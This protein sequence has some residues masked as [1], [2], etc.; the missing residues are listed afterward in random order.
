[1]WFSL[2]LFFFQITRAGIKVLHLRDFLQIYVLFQKNTLELL[3]FL[4]VRVNQTL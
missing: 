3:Q 4:C 2:D 1:M